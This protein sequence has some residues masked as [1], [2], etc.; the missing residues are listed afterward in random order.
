MPSIWRPSRPVFRDPRKQIAKRRR[1]ARDSA[2]KLGRRQQPSLRAAAPSRPMQSTRTGFARHCVDLPRVI[3]SGRDPA[4]RPLR[5]DDGESTAALFSRELARRSPSIAPNRFPGATGITRHVVCQ[6]DVIIL[7]RRTSELGSKW[8]RFHKA[9]GQQRLGVTPIDC[10]MNALN[11]RDTD[12]GLHRS[13]GW[14]RIDPRQETIVTS[15]SLQGAL[16]HG[17]L[18]PRRALPV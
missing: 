6:Y 12:D 2:D 3:G 9:M 7:G 16:G 8:F 14:V 1:C 13:R 18:F 10:S 5:A 4:G 17:G 15:I 11:Q